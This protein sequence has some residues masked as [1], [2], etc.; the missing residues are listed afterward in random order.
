MKSVMR[1][2]IL[3]RGASQ[4]VGHR[5]VAYDYSPLAKGRD[6]GIEG[7]IISSVVRVQVVA[8]P[9]VIVI[10]VH[11]AERIAPGQAKPTFSVHSTP[12]L[13][14]FFAGRSASLGWWSR[15][16]PSVVRLTCVAQACADVA[17]GA[18]GAFT[19]AG[20]W[21]LELIVK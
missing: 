1:V 10:P 15:Y 11:I 12:F 21:K 16:P 14:G 20:M 7:T 2:N 8:N 18:G 9:S 19:L 13:D 5:S 3:K 17:L 4:Q 6:S